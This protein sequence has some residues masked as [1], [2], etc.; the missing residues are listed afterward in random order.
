MGGESMPANMDVE[1]RIMQD[2]LSDLR[3]IAG[4]TAEI[5]AGKLGITKQTISN[6]ETQKVK[7]SRIQYI[8]IRAVFE[9]EVAANSKNTTLRKVIRVL[10]SAI[11]PIY[12][13]RK[14]EVRTA[15]ISIASIAAA[16]ITGLQLYSSATA[17]LAPLGSKV[18]QT[19]GSH[20]GEPS[21]MWLLEALEGSNVLGI[22][23]EEDSEDDTD[24]NAGN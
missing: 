9:C 14:E 5:L 11:P 10:F 24:E 4:W 1:I 17:L 19:E 2:N 21:L 15:M 23:N 12:S 20:I 7:L 8:A 3:K 6:L 16:G 18:M 13:A 22:Q